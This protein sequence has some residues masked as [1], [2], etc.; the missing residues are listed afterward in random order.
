M[1]N[2]NKYIQERF[3]SRDRLTLKEHQLITSEFVKYFSGLD[4]DM[5]VLDAGCGDG[6]FLE[7]LRNLG[8]E[9]IY[10]ID[11]VV[12]LLETARKKGF[13][14]VEGSI[15]DLD[16]RNR[17]D[18]VLLCNVLEYMEN[19]GMAIARVCDALKDDGLLY[20]I[21]AVYDSDVGKS[22]RWFRRRN[23]DEFPRTQGE[24]V[25]SVEEIKGSHDLPQRVF[26]MNGLL[27][28]LESHQFKIEHT[29]KQADSGS[30]SHRRYFK[31]RRGGLI[32]VVARKKSMSSHAITSKAAPLEQRSE[33]EETDEK[34]ETD[35]PFFQNPRSEYEDVDEKT[36]LE[37]DENEHG[38]NNV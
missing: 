25:N 36:V 8:F 35:A 29:F 31:G 38:D 6:F 24:G 22:R 1:T 23:E 5:L 4:T 26:P 28:L 16:V 30:T 9:S 33:P 27:W 18:A 34:E 7:I 37:S 19:P 10:G 11:T 17:L 32:S 3:S 21:V 14:V 13:Q 15:Y 12:P 2:G 20:L